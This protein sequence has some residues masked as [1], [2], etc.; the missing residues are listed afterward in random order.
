[1]QVV[2][3]YFKSAE[4]GVWAYEFGTPADLRAPG[5]IPMTQ[6]EIEARINP[7][8]SIDE[9]AKLAQSF[10]NSQYRSRMQAIADGYPAYERES[11][12]VQLQEAKDLQI[13]AGASTPWLD[14]CAH[15]RGMTKAEL[16]QRVLDK[17]FG[18]RQ[19]SGFLTG[20]R[21]WHEDCIALLLADGENARSELESYDHLQGWE[22][23]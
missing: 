3:E 15:Q 10:V 2:Y 17:D 18:Y 23:A 4:G 7:V 16:A 9:L 5:L 11:W 21:Q 19:V 1:M 20:V 8:K 12:P 6:A 22:P 13:N 14:A